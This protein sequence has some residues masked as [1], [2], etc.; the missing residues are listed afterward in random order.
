MEIIWLYGHFP[1]ISLQNSM[2]NNL[3]P[4]TWSCYIRLCVIMRYLIKGL[5]CIGSDLS[6]QLLLNLL[7]KLIFF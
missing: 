4:T 6:I 1:I 3:E 7:N 2:V 5:R